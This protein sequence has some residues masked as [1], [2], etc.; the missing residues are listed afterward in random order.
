MPATT[1]Q[2]KRFLGLNNVS[3]PLRLKLGWLQRA[4]NLDITDTGALVRRDGY[5]RVSTGAISGAYA[6][7]DF[8][9]MY[10]VDS[11]TLKQVISTTQSIVLRTGLTTRPLHW[12][13]VNDQVFFNNGVDSG[14][15]LKDG[16]V[17]DWAWTDA[18][19]PELAAVSGTLPQGMYQVAFTYL[20]SDGRETGACDAS[21]IYLDG[22]Q[23]LQVNA[24]PQ[25]AGHRTQVYIAP[26]DSTVFQLAFADYAGTSASWNS[27]PDMLGADLTTQ[28]LDP[29]QPGCDYIAYWKG[30]MYAAQYDP[31]SDTTVVWFSEA[32]IFHLFNLN[33]NFILVP[34]KVAMLA[35]HPDGMIIGT[36]TRIYTYDGESIKQVADYGV[37][38]GWGGAKDDD[39]QILFWSRRGLCRAL[40]F[41]NMTLQQI[42]V[43]CGLSAGAAIIRKNGAKRYVVALQKGGDNFN[44]RGTS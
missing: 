34:G 8:T 9:R 4:D 32:L 28:F 11:G 19:M 14:I 1:A 35:A 26:A 27:S 41:S 3:D 33:S 40:P 38:P 13:E 5:V 6:S 37:V 7:I 15:I 25:L 10:I 30:Q 24:I 12:A 21:A 31:A 42:S 23:A 20:T 44:Q 43:D 29:L 17:L 18:P 2:T 39:D 16:T 22:T 36:D